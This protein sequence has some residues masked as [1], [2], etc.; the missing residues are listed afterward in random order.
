MAAISPDTIDPGAA[1][2]YAHLYSGARHLRLPF[3]TQTVANND[4][5]TPQNVSG[6][7]REVVIHA[8]A[9][10]PEAADDEVAVV[11][12]ATNTTVTFTTAEATATGYLH[13]WVNG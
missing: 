12:D 7:G 3:T 2:G 1:G 8:A 5:F 4:T 6:A 11:V 9:W 13:L 10:E